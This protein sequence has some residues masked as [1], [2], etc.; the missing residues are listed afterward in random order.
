MTGNPPPNAAPTISVAISTMDRPES[1]HAC[2][3]GI[4][5]GSD[6]PSEIL[7]VDQSTGLDSRQVAET[8]AAAGA[9]IVYRRQ[10]ARGLSV[11]QNEAVAAARGEVIAVIDD[12]C[13]PERDWLHRIVRTFTGHPE[14]TLVA[15]RVLPLPTSDPDLV[16]VSLRTDERPRV[17]STRAAPWLVGS[18]NNF[19][20]RREAYLLIG[21]CDT[22]LGPGS[23]AMGGVDMDLFYRLIRSGGVARYEPSIVVHHEQK[24]Y[25]D[26]YARRSMYG[27]GTGACF[28]LW[29]RAGDRY[30]L[31]MMARWLAWRSARLLRAVMR[32]D[33]SRA[34][35]E[36]VMLRTT[37]SG[38]AHG[39]KHAQEK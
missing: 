37:L 14:A 5:N 6:L 32:G 2:L 26:R 17:F 7:V 30:A 9:P 39:L 3:V 28:G 35:E 38:F 23:E 13:V 15:G 8:M 29:L 1:L 20:I 34:R 4:M 24:P 31:P 36:A 16:P 19:A 27:F 10:D 12:D 22:R 25:A 11:S 33:A 18:G 21:G